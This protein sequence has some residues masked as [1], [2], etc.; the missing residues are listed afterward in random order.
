MTSTNFSANPNKS[1][2]QNFTAIAVTAG[3]ILLGVLGYL[4]YTN[5]DKAK[6][7][8]KTIVQLDE[9]EKLRAELEANYNQALS[10]LEAQ[11]TTNQELNAII[12]QQKEELLKQKKMISNLIGSKGSLDKAKAEIANLKTQ[13]QGY[14]AQIDNL[15]TENAQL[16]GENAQLTE[17]K[18]KLSTD[19]QN[20]ASENE[21]LSSAKAKLTSEKEEL[22]GKVNIAS[23]VRTKSITAEGQKVRNSGKVVSENSAKS[24]EQIKVCFTTLS[25][26]VAKAG[27]ER[28]FVRI[29]NPKGETLAVESMGSGT[30]INKKTGEDVRF[31]KAADLDFKNSEANQCVVWAPTNPSFVSG[32]YTVEVYNKG[33][34]AGSGTL[35]L[36]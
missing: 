22:T 15:K 24:V 19:L 6:Q 25:N 14:L 12:D 11:K 8:E 13:V 26:E 29:V 9:S 2:K 10:D 20:K 28:F 16:T 7:L 35:T 30:I 3:I 34:L 21:A 5:L 17:E 23:V 32:K 31:T 27:M 36:K 33:Y 1:Q 18:S 4:A